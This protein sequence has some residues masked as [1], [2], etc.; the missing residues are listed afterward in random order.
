M[1]SLRFDLRSFVP[2][3]TKLEMACSVSFQFWW[4][5]LEKFPAGKGL[6]RTIQKWKNELQKMDFK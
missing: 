5:N 6:S 4:P 3:E 1:I 2:E